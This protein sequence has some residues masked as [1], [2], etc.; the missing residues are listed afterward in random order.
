MKPDVSESELNKT[1]LMLA[2]ENGQ[3]AV[4]LLLVD[5][6]ANLEAQDQIA[7]W[8][9]T[10]PNFQG[11][12]LM[13]AV[14]GGHADTVEALLK[15]EANPNAVNASQQTVLMIAR[16]KGDARILQLLKKAGAKE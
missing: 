1:A 7:P 2:A 15:R 4:A 11:T 9:D 12:P 5:R 3:T 14:H 10:G 13:W 6:G 8:D 16:E